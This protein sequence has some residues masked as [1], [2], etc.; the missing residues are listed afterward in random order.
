VAL[1]LMDEKSRGDV[2]SVPARI[3][4]RNPTIDSIS[5]SCA[6]AYEKTRYRLIAVLMYFLITSHFRVEFF[7]KWP[8]VRDS[9]AL[10]ASRSGHL[11]TQCF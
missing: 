1:S 7:M 10:F 4:L 6:T 3:D 8:I 11:S 2:L 9:C 5:I